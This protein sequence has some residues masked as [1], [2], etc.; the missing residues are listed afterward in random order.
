M[1]LSRRYAIKSIKCQKR[2]KFM[3]YQR[4]LIAWQNF[5][6]G[7]KATPEINRFQYDPFANLEQLVYEIDT[8]TYHHGGYR[9]VVIE[10]KKR[11]D[12]AVATVRDRVAH[13]LVY[14]ELN[15]ICDKTFDPDVWSC[16]KSKGL[17]K[18]L[19]RTQRLVRKYHADFIWRM[20]I[21]KFFDNVDHAILKKCL[22]R[23]VHNP[24][25]LYLCDEIIDSY[26]LAG[27]SDGQPVYQ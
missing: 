11:R 7:K 10:E 19:A 2:N 8:R 18:C 9:K 15:G 13:R 16:R 17:H 3:L 6:K 12:L 5:R 27:G 20:D 21:S 26:T 22:R 1:T 23:R 14:D 25:T 4:L 24:Q